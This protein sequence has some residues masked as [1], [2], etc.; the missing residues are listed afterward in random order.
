MGLEESKPLGTGAL[1]LLSA[2]GSL[3]MCVCV[4]IAARVEKK[5]EM[6]WEGE[7]GEGGIERG[8]REGGRE[9]G[10]MQRCILSVVFYIE[11]F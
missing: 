9:G 6:A 4:L 3:G 5:Q 8:K 7:G 11:K 2:S 10:Q 1:G